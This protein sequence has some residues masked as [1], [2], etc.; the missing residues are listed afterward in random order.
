MVF[1]MKNVRL[2]LVLKIFFSINVI[3]VKCTS[4]CYCYYN[5][6]YSGYRETCYYY[7]Y[8]YYYSGGPTSGA[9][10][11]IVVNSVFSFIGF[12]CLVKNCVKVC[13]EPNHVPMDVRPAPPAQTTVSYIDTT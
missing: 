7:Y 5:Y 10:A 1:E 4:Y 3:P 2:F 8:Y 11:G 9:I 13:K 12:V 6:Y